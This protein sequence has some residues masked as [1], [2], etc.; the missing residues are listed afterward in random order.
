M[1]ESASIDK[2]SH[3]RNPCGSIGEVAQLEEALTTAL[4]FAENHPETLVVVTA[5]HAQ[6]AQI[7]PEPSVAGDDLSASFSPGKVA[8]IKTPEGSLMAINYAT[9]V[10]SSAKHTG[11]NVPLFANAE[12]AKLL[13]PYLRQRDL[14]QAMLNYLGLAQ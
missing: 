4:A 10:R 5:D 3:A 13:P 9:T 12:G 6:A 2:Q 1:I 14:Y 8:R 7:I 11:A